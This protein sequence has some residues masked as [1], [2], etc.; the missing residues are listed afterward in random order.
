MGDVIEGTTVGLLIQAAV[1]VADV[2][3][4]PGDNSQIS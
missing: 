3:V 4:A 2:D 1:L